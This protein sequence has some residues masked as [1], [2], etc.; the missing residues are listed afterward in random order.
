MWPGPGGASSNMMAAGT[1]KPGRRPAAVT[2]T[3]AAGRASSVSLAPNKA[4]RAKA[5]Y[6]AR[7]FVRAVP[8]AG[9]VVCAAGACGPGLLTVGLILHRQR[10]I[11]SEHEAEARVHEALRDAG[12]AGRGS[13]PAHPTL[14]L[15]VTP[16]HCATALVK[17]RDTRP[18]E[19]LPRKLHEQHGPHGRPQRASPASPTPA[20]P[21]AVGWRRTRAWPAPSPPRA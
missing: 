8:G 14:C 10:H 16:L 15:T 6:E 13:V 20:R 17:G 4:R 11:A 9:G 7:R 12:A 18:P 5:S 21:P 1:A 2:Q 19:A 3:L